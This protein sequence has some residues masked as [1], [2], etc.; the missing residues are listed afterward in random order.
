ML[1]VGSGDS[2]DG[3]SDG[4]RDGRHGIAELHLQ[5]LAGRAL[6]AGITLTWDV[7]IAELVGNVDNRSGARGIL[8][9]IE[10]RVGE[11]L[12]LRIVEGLEP[13][14]ALHA[15]VVDDEVVLTD[16]VPERQSRAGEAIPDTVN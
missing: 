15:T 6:E 9:A 14:A 2:V 12:G 1:N 10:E 16:A 13:A 4:L 11:P 7:S 8:R 3:P 5:K